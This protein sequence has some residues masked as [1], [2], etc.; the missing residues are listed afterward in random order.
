M[1]G[2]LYIVSGA[3]GS[4]K[5]T[6]VDLII[7]ECEGVVQVPK[8]S[9][10]ASRGPHDDTKHVEE[11]GSEEYDITYVLNDYYYGIKTWE[12]EAQINEGKDAFIILSDFKMIRRLKERF[13]DNSSSIYVSSAVDPL[14]LQRVMAERHANEIDPTTE[15]SIALRKNFYKLQCSAQLD[16]WSTVLEGMSDL[17]QEWN[18]VV[19][20]AESARIRSEKIRSFHLRYIDQLTLFDYVILNHSQGNPKDMLRQGKKIFENRA[21]RDTPSKK[22]PVLFVV[23]AA[24]GAGKGLLMETTGRLIG[25]KRIGIVRKQA[26]REAKV[27]DRR[28]GLEALGVDGTFSSGFDFDWTFHKSEKNDGHNGT[29]YAINT[30]AVKVGLA[31]GITQIV[32]SNIGIFPRFREVFGEQVVFIYLHS[33]RPESEVRAYQLQNCDTQEEAEKRI[34]EIREVHDSYMNN[35]WQFHH[36]LLNTSYKEDLFDQMLELARHHK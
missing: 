1:T 7:D 25:P 35:I 8:Y 5:T 17:L 2:H 19:P 14:T 9:E 26:L 18:D 34:Q 28:D 6:L 10:R 12:I 31:E 11:V 20:H 24:S 32:V 33:T 13:P 22:E 36:V 27:N 30:K 3:S 4:G 15:Q 29:R 16:R 21:E 23:A